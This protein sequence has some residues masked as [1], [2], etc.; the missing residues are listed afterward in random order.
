M[1]YGLNIVNDFNNIQISSNYKTYQI[2]SRGVV[3]TNSQF[4][5][6]YGASGGF[7]GTSKTEPGVAVLNV[8][9][10]HQLFIRPVIPDPSVAITAYCPQDWPVRW[11]GALDV[12]SSPQYVNGYKCYLLIAKLH[13]PKISTLL[14]RR[15]I[16]SDWANLTTTMYCENLNIQIE[17]IICSVVDNLPDV[18]SGHG[19]NVYNNDGQMCYT[20]SLRIPTTVSIISSTYTNYAAAS[21]DLSSSSSVGTSMFIDAS[22]LKY[23]GR[24]KRTNSTIHHH[25][26]N[27]VVWTSLSTGYIDLLDI[28]GI[29][30]SAYSGP[31]IN[32]YEAGYTSDSKVPP[33]NTGTYQFIKVI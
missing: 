17:F 12:L 13:T 7:Y 22:N 14:G 16:N 32:N 4:N 26:T 6:I 15:T 8:P 19:L 18:T 5:Y 28:N 23:F 20:S 2:V 21:F 3:N 1:E 9:L 30:D 27:A 24:I 25:F 11:N 33:V 10:G 29:P 31:Y